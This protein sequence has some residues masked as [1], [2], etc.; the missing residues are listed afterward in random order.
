MSDIC[1]NSLAEIIVDD[2]SQKDL[3]KL[4]FAHELERL[5]SLSP[6]EMQRIAAA[7]NYNPDE[8]L[9]IKWLKVS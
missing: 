5:E 7:Y 6:E 3:F 2:Y 1:L 9:E 4:A 8:W